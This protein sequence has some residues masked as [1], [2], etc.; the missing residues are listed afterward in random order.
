MASTLAV[1]QI[2]K[3]SGDTFILPASDGTAGQVLST[4]ASGQLSF[5][6]AD[7]DS[8]KGSDV[9]S[10]SPCVI[11]DGDLYYDVTGTT[12]FAA[13]TVSVGR[14]FFVQFD[15]ILT[16]AHHATNLD[17]PGADDIVTAAGD[18]A[19]FFAHTANQVQCVNYT[20]ASG[21][22][23][24]IAD[25]S[26]D[27]DAYVDGSIDNAHIADNAID[28][29]HY[30]DGSIDNAHIADNAIDSEHY[31]DGSIDNAHIADDAI[32]SEHYVDGSI[33][34]A[35]IADD[36][37]DSEHYADGS[38]DTAHIAADAIDGTLIADNAIDSEHYTDGSIDNAHIADDAIDS[39]HYADGS[40]DNA[41]IADDAID[42]EHY[43][44]G[45]I[46]SA[47]LATG[48][49]LDDVLLKDY[50][51]TTNALGSAGGARTI[52]LTLGNSVSATVSSSTV[53]WTFSNPTASDEGCGFTLV[54]TNGGS[55]TVNW[56][57]S[58]DWAGGTA[59]TLT[60]SGVDVLAFWTVDGGTIWY[61]FAASLDNS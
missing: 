5:I 24:K 35:H 50:G 29:E 17:L 39:E 48:I 14:H 25:N 27:S 47:H 51:E 59:P 21:A 23:V 43:A 33:D 11:P 7:P 49:V 42:S 13:F 1:D 16:M 9:A 61:G 2:K 4:N 28:S 12:N 60:S 34:N 30:A 19:E 52:N 53:T 57:G 6:D 38:I 36:A 15:G 46:D 18:V 58:V 41:H 22:S 20:R 37:I 3:Q 31:A 40:I 10:A 55:Q 26:I 44:D 8:G 54:L 45:S 56:P 32:D